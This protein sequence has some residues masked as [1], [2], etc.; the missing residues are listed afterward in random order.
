[1]DESHFASLMAERNKTNSN[2]IR[3]KTRDIYVLKNATIATLFFAPPHAYQ[4][5]IIRKSNRLI[6]TPTPTPTNIPLTN[7]S[8]TLYYQAFRTVSKSAYKPESSIPWVHNCMMVS[9]VRA[10]WKVAVPW[11]AW[12]NERDTAGGRVARGRLALPHNIQ[13]VINVGCR[14]LAKVVWQRGI[15]VDPLRLH[16]LCGKEHGSSS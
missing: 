9:R 16:T 12:D 5:S 4:N 2:S 11:R 7:N 6:T 1:M 15:E 10:R 13:V 3:K 8:A 14:N